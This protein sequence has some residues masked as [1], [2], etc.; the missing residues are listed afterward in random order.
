MMI[1][2]KGRYALRVMADM[3][4]Y[5]EEGYL[6]LGDVA[7]REDISMK[8]LE[9][10]VASLC[11]CKLLDSK[12]GKSGGY[13]LCKAPEEYTVGEIIK[14]AEGGLTPVGC[15]E[16]EGE[17]CSR[18]GTCITLPLWRTMDAMIENYLGSITLADLINGVVEPVK[19]SE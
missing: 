8:Y 6:S 1:S 3:A 18:A 11:H 17:T 15:P 14:A 5:A 2:T 19:V 10:I 12:R 16:C 13:R 7:K 4:Q 9:A